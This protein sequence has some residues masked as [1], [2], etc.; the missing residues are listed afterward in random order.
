MFFNL[1]LSALLLACCTLQHATASYALVA[2]KNT[3]EAAFLYNFALFIEW[4]ASSAN[5]FR[6][7]VL[8]STPVLAALE[9]VKKKQIKGHPIIITEISAVQQVLPCHILF[10]GKSE[11]AS[12]GA[13]AKYIGNAPILVVA[14]ENG[15]DLKNVTIALVA[16]QDHIAFRINRTAAEANSL[17]ISSKLLKLA[18]KVY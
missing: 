8:G 6:I 9:P 14:E 16:E 1:R 10:V 7:C 4:P 17:T 12:L 11:H 18:L 2:D 15:F 13:L 3:I 5:E